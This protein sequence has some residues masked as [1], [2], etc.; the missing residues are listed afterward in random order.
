MEM[1]L[2]SR[3][4]SRKLGGKVW[5]EDEASRPLPV[6]SRHRPG[7]SGQHPPRR[8]SQ[9]GQAVYHPAS[10]QEDLRRRDFTVNAMAISLNEGSFGC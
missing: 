5:G 1:R 2:S 6:F 9:A 10:I 4:Q 8:V 7:G 3:K